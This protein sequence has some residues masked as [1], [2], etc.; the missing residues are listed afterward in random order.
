ML[1]L[2]ENSAFNEVC[3]DTNDEEVG[4]IQKREFLTWNN[5]PGQFGPPK[6]ERD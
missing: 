1:D 5:L 4:E 3:D 6:S 2:S